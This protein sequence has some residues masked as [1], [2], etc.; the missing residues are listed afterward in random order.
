[1]SDPL[2]NDY[3]RVPSSSESEETRA[4]LAVVTQAH[5][6]GA[7]G[8][9]TWEVLEALGLSTRATEMLRSRG[10]QIVRTDSLAVQGVRDGI[11]RL[12][13]RGGAA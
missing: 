11:G 7:P 10:A 2:R 13:S 12:R 8:S 1:M 3:S 5:R 6:L 4:V 9:D